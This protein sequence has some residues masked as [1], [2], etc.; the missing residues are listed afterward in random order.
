[1]DDSLETLPCMNVTPRM[2]AD[3]YSISLPTVYRWVREL[4]L[5]GV[6][7]GRRV[8]R[9]SE[10][11]LIEWEKLKLAGDRSQARPP[12]E[13]G[14]PGVLPEE[15]LAPGSEET[16]KRPR[17]RRRRRAKSIFRMDAPA[18]NLVRESE[19]G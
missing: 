16:S 1:M 3:R 11:D 17:A 5:P 12:D 7:L 14:G 9:F 4:K 13:S 15:G 19:N 2:V 18:E 8:L 10:V 6:R